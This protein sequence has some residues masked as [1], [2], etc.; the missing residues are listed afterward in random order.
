MSGNHVLQ[1]AADV[2]SG[3]TAST[4]EKRLAP[5]DGGSIIGA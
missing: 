3:S 5:S 4:T 2:L 1:L